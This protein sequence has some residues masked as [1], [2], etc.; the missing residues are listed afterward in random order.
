MAI[1]EYHR[2]H[3]KPSSLHEPSRVPPPEVVLLPPGLLSSVNM[4]R[5]RQ[6]LSS[7][8]SSCGYRL[9]ILQSKG[10]GRSHL[11]QLSLNHPVETRLIL[12]DSGESVHLGMD[13]LHRFVHSGQLLR[14][15]LIDLRLAVDK[16]SQ[17]RLVE[18]KEFEFPLP[19][20]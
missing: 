19:P 2:I 8:T 6:I 10:H 16:I 13:S 15:G 20:W 17:G 14:K 12:D 7:F 1:L 3:A 11:S 4:V 9:N 5:I 18:P